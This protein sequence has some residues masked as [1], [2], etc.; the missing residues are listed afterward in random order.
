MWPETSTPPRSRLVKRKTKQLTCGPLRQWGRFLFVG[1]SSRSRTPLP[2]GSSVRT[3]TLASS[4]LVGPKGWRSRGEP[5][6]LSSYVTGS[7]TGTVDYQGRTYRLSV[8]SFGFGTIGGLR[9]RTGGHRSQ[10]ADRGGH[11]RHVQGGGAAG[12]TVGAGGQV[13]R[14]QNANCVSNRSKARTLGGFTGR[15]DTLPESFHKERSACE[16][17]RHAARSSRGSAMDRKRRWRASP[18]QPQ[19]DIGCHSGRPLS[20]RESRGSPAGSRRF[21][22]AGWKLRPEC[23]RKNR[24]HR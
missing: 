15:G 9:G 13:A 5:L 20:L 2:V 16:L 11:C 14:F 12:L 23:R 7:G 21:G 19:Q 1:Y 10:F 3:R 8:S 17:D 4:Y 22:C 18:F 6:R 24:D